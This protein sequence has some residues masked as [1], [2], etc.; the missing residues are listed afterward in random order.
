MCIVCLPCVSIC[1]FPTLGVM[2]GSDRGVACE[3][4]THAR[5]VIFHIPCIHVAS[6][7]CGPGDVSGGGPA[8]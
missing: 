8:E 4:R 5:F 2:F 6:P 3:K 7:P 1:V